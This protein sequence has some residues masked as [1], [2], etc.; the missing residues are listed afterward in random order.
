M[1]TA[2]IYLVDDHTIVRKS[3]KDLVE[4]LGDYTVLKDYSSGKELISELPFSPPPDLI[5]LDIDM[6]NMTGLEVMQY[7][8][9]N[10]ITHPVLALTFDT[11]DDTI[12]QLFRLGIKGY[13]PKK[14]E[15]NE[16]KQAIDDITKT[17]YFFTEILFNALAKE[18]DKQP[19]ENE[20]VYKQ[21]TT[22]EKDFLRLVC[23]PEEYTYEQIADIM[24]VHRRTVDGYRSALFEK[25]EIKSKAGLILFAI[26]YNLIETL[27]NNS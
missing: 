4:C 5:I 11:T 15:P 13:L 23:D 27:K 6:P 25:Y 8:K 14:C 7:F 24:N 21:L 26:K 19:D 10:E 1:S 20:Q 17:G 18:E 12:A 22:R 16:L 9:E 3:L 2:N